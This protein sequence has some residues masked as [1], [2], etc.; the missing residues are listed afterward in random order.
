MN[1]CSLIIVLF[2]LTI[3]E[4]SYAGE[5]AFFSDEINN[6]FKTDLTGFLKRLPQNQGQQG[7][8]REVLS[9]SEYEK[10]LLFIDLPFSFE[11]IDQASKLKSP[12]LLIETLDI[13]S[14]N[15][16][17]KVSFSDWYMSKLFLLIEEKPELYILPFLHFC[18]KSDGEFAEGLAHPL[19]EFISNYPEEFS[20]GLQTLNNVKKLCGIMETGDYKLVSR[21]LNKL[22]YYNKTKN[23]KN[24]NDLLD[25]FIPS[26]KS[27]SN[28]DSPSE[29]NTDGGKTIDNSHP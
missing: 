28:T 10:I 9:Y 11:K 21:S 4:S 18:Q 1:K 29:G 27:N 26:G 5:D 17:L 16:N 23:I 19:A 2:I 12:F 15:L 7:R 24:V 3:N 8:V 6:E 20:K 13:L 22:A 14:N 25:C